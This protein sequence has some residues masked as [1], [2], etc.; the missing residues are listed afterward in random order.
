MCSDLWG[1]YLSLGLDY[2]QKNIGYVC[3]SYDDGSV[4]VIHT[5]MNKEMLAGLE[6]NKPELGLYDVDKYR[7]IDL[8]F[9]SSD[10][11][12]TITD[13]PPRL[14]EVNSFVNRFF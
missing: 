5:T 11:V 2:L 3:F 13:T 4:V 9:I 14:S 7:W 12:M 8:S 10:S 6:Y 1:D